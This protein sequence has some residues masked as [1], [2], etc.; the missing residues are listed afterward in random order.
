M[1]AFAIEF[2]WAVD[3]AGYDWVPGS[4]SSIAANRQ[5]PAQ[6]VPR[7]GMLRAIHP[8]EAAGGELHRIF[9]STVGNPEALLDFICRFGPLTADGNRAHGEDAIIGLAG[10]ETMAR[11][12][13]AYAGAPEDYRKTLGP[14]DNR[15]T[16][17]DGFLGW[18]N[19]YLALNP[20]TRRPQ[21]RFLPVCLIDAMLLEFGRVVTSD[22]QLRQCVQCGIWFETGP[23]TGRR[24][25]AKF[26]SDS[27]RISYSSLKRTQKGTT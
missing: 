20:V 17:G 12:L 15:K 24:A 7:S 19:A 26:C 11:W 22:A 10:A 2:Q 4:P 6:I 16:Y 27:H 8:L 3:E 14:E 25:D 9:A 23:G 1:T 13:A 5:I 21:L 18:V